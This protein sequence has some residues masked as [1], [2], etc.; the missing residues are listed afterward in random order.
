VA[1]FLVIGLVIFFFYRHDPIRTQAVSSR[2][3]REATPLLLG[4]LCGLIGE[5]SGIVNIGIEGQIT[6][7]GFAAFFMAA[8]QLISYLVGLVLSI[9]V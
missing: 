2:T 1:G 7:A 8:D 5:R 9:R 4:A 3:V 6:L